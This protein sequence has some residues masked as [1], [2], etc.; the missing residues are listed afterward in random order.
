MSILFL[1]L[2]MVCILVAIVCFV[3]ILIDAFKDELWKG[4]AGLLCG[5]YLMYYSLVEFEHEKKFLIVGGWFFGIMLG[6]GF[7]YLAGGK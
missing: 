7:L 6:R 3:I 4:I 5:I 2:A 1:I